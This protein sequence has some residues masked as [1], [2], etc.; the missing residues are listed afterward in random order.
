[1]RRVRS[2]RPCKHG[3]GNA[4]LCPA[5]GG[6]SDVREQRPRAESPAAALWGRESPSPHVPHESRVRGDR[7]PRNHQMFL[8]IAAHALAKRLAS[9]GKPHLHRHL[10]AKEWRR[11]SSAWNRDIRLRNSRPSHGSQSGRQ[12]ERTV[13]WPCLLLA[14]IRL[15]RRE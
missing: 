7:V 13:R 2:P 10:G 3:G 5:S 4:Q 8:G 12:W 9:N 6:C 11:R 15:T 1:M 14:T